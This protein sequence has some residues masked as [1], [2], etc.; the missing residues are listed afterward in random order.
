MHHLLRRRRFHL[1]P[2]HRIERRLLEARQ[3]LGGLHAHRLG[4]PAAIGDEPG[5]HRDRMPAGLREHRRALAVEPLG[6]GRE[7][8]PQADV[9]LDHREPVARGQMVEPVPQA[10]G[11]VAAHCP[12]PP[13]WAASR[14]W[15][16]RADVS[17]LRRQG[18]PT[19]EH[20]CLISARAFWRASRAIRTRWRS[21][22]ASVRL[23][24][25]EWYRRISALVAGFDA[26]GLKPGDHL[27]TVLQNR[28]QA[29]TIHWACQFAGIIIT[30][31]N[32][33]STAENS[34]FA[35]TMPRPRRS[36]TRR[37][38]R[39]PC[40]P[41][42]GRQACRTSRSGCRGDIAFEALVAARRA[43]RAARAPT[44]RPGR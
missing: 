37:R 24:Y 21:S 12:V 36:S 3:H 25:R 27:V 42:P 17:S 34:T 6:I 33:R 8:E 20:P 11:P 39:K 22:T 29:A 31:L 26:L 5:H 28:W 18:T 15:S 40:A 23:T 13:G 38:R 7:L 32:W 44:P 41:R 2:R 30:P 4:H 14:A 35:S 10:C 43:G 16:W 19:T 9:G 1:L